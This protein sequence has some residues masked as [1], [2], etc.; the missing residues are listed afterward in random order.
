MPA[1]TVVLF[2]GEDG[3]CPLLVWL[4]LLPTKAQDKCIVRDE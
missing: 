4:D 1:T 3:I 2:V